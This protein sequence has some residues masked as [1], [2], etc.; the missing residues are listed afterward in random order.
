MSREVTQI[1]NHASLALAR[2]AQQYKDKPKLAALLGVFTPKVQELENVLWALHVE[3]RID[4]AVGAQLDVLGRIVGQ[5][6]ENSVDADYRLRIKA[7]VRANRSHGSVE[8]VLEV[9]Q[10]LLPSTVLEFVQEWP[11]AFRLN[12]GTISGSGV[13]LVPMYARFLADAKLGG[14]GG[15]LLWQQTSDAESYY[16]EVAA[17]LNGSHGA[18]S[19]TLT[20]DNP[21]SNALFPS[22]GSLKLDEGVPGVEETVTYSGKTASSFTGVSATVNIHPDNAAVSLVGSTGKG[23]P[24]ATFA[25]ADHT[26]GATTLNADT[27]GFDSPSGTLLLEPGT[28]VEETVT[29]TGTT[30]STFT[31]V[32]ATLFAHATGATFTKAGTGGRLAGAL[33]P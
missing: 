7:R 4:V 10:I 27:T 6:R 2:L 11:A 9:F 17:F 1:L 3:R 16:T 31:G 23:H 15:Y 24:R 19:T 25:T 5:L 13:A 33:L 32:S 8:D 29:Y 20:I 28:A 12:I 21:P 18:G 26:V 14:V 22:S 30:G